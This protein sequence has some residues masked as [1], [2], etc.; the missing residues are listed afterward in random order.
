MSAANH[1]PLIANR[2]LLAS[3]A[4]LT[5]P[6]TTVEQPT[7]ARHDTFAPRFGW[8]K[9]GFDAAVA[10]PG[11]FSREDAPVR[12]GVGKNMVRA[13]KH[14][15]LATGLIAD[16]VSTGRQFD[17]TP[18]A[19]GSYLLGDEGVDPFLED[20]GSLWL[21]HWRLVGNGNLATGWWY[22]FY[23]FPLNEFD[24]DEL[25]DALKDF[26]D[27]N[28][29]S[30]RYARSSY[31]K[32]ASCLVRMYGEMPTG[33][34]SEETLYSPFAELTLLRPIDNKRY[35]FQTGAKASLSDE[36]VLFAAAEFAMT[37]STTL[38]SIPL[39][40]LMREPG[41]PGLAFRLGEAA[42][43]AALERAA[44]QGGVSIADS[45]GMIQVFFDAEPSKIA[46]AT[47]AQHYAERTGGAI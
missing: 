12:L 27:V 22:A 34:A 23:G 35:A 8:L 19:L 39:A 38:R 13:I 25:T 20:L 44:E 33:L 5:P 11:I 30:N 1:E 14:W 4:L 42:L 28:F 21:L 47:L 43:Y 17:A 32:D 10:D 45:G 29:P 15:T 2:G 6:T 46:Q 16:D 31:R 37:R 3:G 41:S 40:A 18:T 36:I 7:F 24:V 26:V 9:K